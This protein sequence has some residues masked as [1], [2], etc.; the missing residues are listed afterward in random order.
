MGGRGGWGQAVSELLIC[1][2]NRDVTRRDTAEL[3]DSST[4]S[5]GTPKEALGPWWGAGV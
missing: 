2:E 3:S 4:K 5:Q 1:S